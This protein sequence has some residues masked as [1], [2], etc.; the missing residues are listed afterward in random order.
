MTIGMAEGFDL[1]HVSALA[2]FADVDRETD[3]GGKE[4]GLEW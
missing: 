4:A 2:L 3:D 1:D